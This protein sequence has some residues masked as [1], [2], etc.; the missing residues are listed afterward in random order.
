MVRF[1]YL[2]SRL[3]KFFYHY[4]F[5]LAR[6]PLFFIII[7][8]IFSL[9]ICSRLV[10]LPID[11]LKD[12]IQLY[13]PSTGRAM[14]DAMEL[15]RL[16]PINDT[17]PWYA[18]RRFEF[19]HAGYIILTRHDKGNLLEPGDNY[20]YP[21]IHRA[22]QIFDDIAKIPLYRPGKILTYQDNLCVLMPDVP[23]EA[24]ICLLSPILAYFYYFRDAAQGVVYPELPISEN[25]QVRF[26]N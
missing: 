1:D 25:Y 10:L 4:A 26:M 9:L 20:T 16:F 5:F 17:D 19:R 22:T 2:E 12:T 11:I 24:H 23:P 3:A 14:S 6:R 13:V 21:Y 8:L 7:P 18:I 15:S